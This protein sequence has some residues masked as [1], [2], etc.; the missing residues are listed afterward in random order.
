MTSLLPALVN[1]DELKTSHAYDESLE[2]THQRINIPL[3]ARIERCQRLKRKSRTEVEL[4]KWYAEEEG[5]RDALLHRDRTDQF[6]CSLPAVFDRYAMGLEDGRS[7]ILAAC[8][9]R[10]NG[11]HPDDH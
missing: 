5:L 11:N 6:R 4:D 8:V 9:E 2:V 3:I 10:A 7:I 1:P